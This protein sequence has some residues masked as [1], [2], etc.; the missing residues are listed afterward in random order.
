MSDNSEQYTDNELYKILCGEEGDNYIALLFSRC[1]GGEAKLLEH[2]LNLGFNE[3]IN[4]AIVK[5]QFAKD[6]RAK[7]AG[8]ESRD[9]S[10]APIRKRMA[11]MIAQLRNFTL[12]RLRYR[13]KTLLETAAESQQAESAKV[14][15]EFG[16]KPTAYRKSD[17]LPLWLV[18]ALPKQSEQEASVVAG[19]D[20]GAKTALAFLRYGAKCRAE[21]IPDIEALYVSLAIGMTE[22]KAELALAL[23]EG[24]IIDIETLNAVEQE[25]PLLF[26]VAINPTAS[27]QK[28][29]SSLIEKNIQLNARDNKM[30]TLVHYLAESSLPQDIVLLEQLLAKSP[31]LIDKQDPKGNTALGVAA[32]QGKVEAVRVLLK[33]GATIEKLNRKHYSPLHLAAMGETEAH[34][35]VLEMILEKFPKKVNQRGKNKSTALHLAVHARNEHSIVA[36]TEHKADVSL[37][38]ENKATPLHLLIQQFVTALGDGG[39]A[40]SEQQGYALA[41]NAMRTRLQEQGKTLQSLGED[42]KGNTVEDYLRNNP[43]AQAILDTGVGLGMAA[44]IKGHKTPGEK[45]GTGVSM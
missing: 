36:L 19:T 2:S 32:K 26:Q 8:Q 24:N 23:I 37:R 16:T 14:L 35:E 20:A 38:D 42:K 45:S 6:A 34:T 39:T 31:E 29:L 41:L 3:P 9:I 44:R 22:H 21:E 5:A 33:A 18:A 4:Q 30:R 7:A 40:M 27:Q 1:I 13:D 17:G 10:E 11:P 12:E 43:V 25:V 28:L 15:L